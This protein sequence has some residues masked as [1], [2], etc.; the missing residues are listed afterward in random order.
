M[1]RLIRG[2]K[3]GLRGI[4]VDRVEPVLFSKVPFV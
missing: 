2:N 1:E 3:T 4:A